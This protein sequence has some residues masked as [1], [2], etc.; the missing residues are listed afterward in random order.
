MESDLFYFDGHPCLNSL[1]SFYNYYFT[2]GGIN[3]PLFLIQLFCFFDWN[4]IGISKAS[5][6]K[7]C[8]SLNL[9]SILKIFIMASHWESTSGVNILQYAY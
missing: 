5:E 9:I 8:F 2:N 3:H 4:I 1:N 7:K 6:C